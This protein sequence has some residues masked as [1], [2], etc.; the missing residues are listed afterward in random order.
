MDVFAVKRYGGDKDSDP[1]H[2]H[3]SL[4]S[5]DADGWSVISNGDLPFDTDEE[6]YGGSCR[7]LVYFAGRK[8]TFVV[9][10]LTTRKWKVLP[11]PDNL[12]FSTPVIMEGCG[13]GYDPQ[14]DDYKIL[15]YC[16]QYKLN[17][18]EEDDSYNG[19]DSYTE[20][21]SFKSG[22]WKD[23]ETPGACVAHAPALYHEGS[24]Y[25]TAVLN[26]NFGGKDHHSGV[27]DHIL[28][29]DLANESF[30]H[31]SFPYS[32][33]A[34]DGQSRVFKYHGRLAALIHGRSTKPLHINFFQRREDIWELLFDILLD[35]VS[36]PLGFGESRDGYILYLEG[37]GRELVA[38]NFKS[39]S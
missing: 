20:V 5:H 18:D 31:L 32:S 3:L 7:G 24:C 28:T 23:I 38:Y 22:S 16:F 1:K 39:N 25:W 13:L 19:V 14:S 29:F 11:P 27:D 34:Y 26:D 12:S 8:G 21:Y 15:R 33:L 4:V 9:C 2:H 36:R 37:N 6:V 35:H 30:G 10:N 17:E